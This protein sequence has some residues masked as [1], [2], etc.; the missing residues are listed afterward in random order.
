MGAVLC[1]Q[2]DSDMDW[3]KL[4][5]APIQARC[6][7]RGDI[8]HIRCACHHHHSG[9]LSGHKGQGPSRPI[10]RCQLA[11]YSAFGSSHGPHQ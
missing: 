8:E 7:E 3:F 9:C 1:L 2:E 11:I 6:K 5:V 10:R 4:D